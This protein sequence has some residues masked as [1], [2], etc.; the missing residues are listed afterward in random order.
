MAMMN[1]KPNI[2]LNNRAKMTPTPSATIPQMV[3]TTKGLA[4]KVAAPRYRTQPW[5]GGLKQL[6]KNYGVRLI[7]KAGPA[8]A[9]KKRVTATG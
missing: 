4:D 5:D 8:K 7:P 9:V 1:S 2:K 6:N 3:N